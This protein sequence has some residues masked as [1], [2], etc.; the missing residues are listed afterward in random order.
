MLLGPCACAPQHARV[1]GPSDVR[2]LDPVS[3]A[4]SSCFR[5]SVVAARRRTEKV[6]SGFLLLT[7][8]IHRTLL[9]RLFQHSSIRALRE[10]R[11]RD[12]SMMSCACSGG[13][14]R[15]SGGWREGAAKSPNSPAG[16]GARGPTWRWSWDRA[17]LRPPRSNLPD[18]GSGRHVGSAHFSYPRPCSR[19]PV[20]SGAPERRAVA[21]AAARRAKPASG[22][23]RAEPSD[24]IAV[25]DRNRDPYQTAVR[26][27]LLD[28]VRELA[29]TRLA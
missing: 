9:K 26:R 10:R 15:C 16:N 23:A 12:S 7:I 6:P 17:A 13:R 29:A 5:A 20:L 25:I 24:M 28:T 19:P 4:T 27:R 2:P 14:P 8:A 3:P 11:N 18:T 21:A 22:H 1:H